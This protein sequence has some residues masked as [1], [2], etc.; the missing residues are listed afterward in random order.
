MINETKEFV[1]RNLIEGAKDD[2]EFVKKNHPH[3]ERMIVFYKRRWKAAK[4]RLNDHLNLKAT[5]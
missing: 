1:F 5:G 3:D 2:F 4:K